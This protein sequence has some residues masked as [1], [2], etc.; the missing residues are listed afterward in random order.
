MPTLQNTS[1][2]AFNEIKINKIQISNLF[3]KNQKEGGFID[4]IVEEDL[5]HQEDKIRISKS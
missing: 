1:N 4:R 3:P 5:K 2:L